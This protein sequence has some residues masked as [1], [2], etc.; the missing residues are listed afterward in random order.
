VVVVDSRPVEDEILDRVLR[1][2]GARRRR[3]AR[4]VPVVSKGLRRRL[5]DRAEGSGLLR[6]ERVRILGLFPVERWPAADPR[7]RREVLRRLREV[8]V[9]GASADPR[10]SAL[11]ALLSSVGAAHLVVGPLPRAQRKAVQRRA[12]EIGQEPWAAEAVRRAV[13]AVQAAVA[14]GAAGAVVAATSASS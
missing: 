6:A 5:L 11:I 8:L 3:A 14:A 10:T 12:N 13:A 1:E 2:A 7:P 4:L 9:D